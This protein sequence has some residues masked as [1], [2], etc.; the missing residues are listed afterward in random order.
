LQYL[1]LIALAPIVHHT[2]RREWWKGLA[3]ILL[4]PFYYCFLFPYVGIRWLG[5]LTAILWRALRFAKSPTGFVIAMLLF[6]VFSIVI[7]VVRNPTALS[8]LG[9]ANLTIMNVLFLCAVVFSNRP[10]DL[11]ILAVRTLCRSFESSVE[12]QRKMELASKAEVERALSSMQSLSSWLRKHVVDETGGLRNVEVLRRWIGPMF[13]VIVFGLFLVFV[14]GYALVYYSLQSAGVDVLPSLGEA[15]SVGLA[16]YN[17]LTISTTA[18]HQGV[19]P[20]SS[21]GRVIQSLHLISVLIFLG[22][23]LFLFSYAMGDRGSQLLG[24]LRELPKRGISKLDRLIDNL[25][26]LESLPS[27]DGDTIDMEGEGDEAT[28]NNVGSEP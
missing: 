17:S 28:G 26:S 15:P 2:I 23:S 9:Y 7:P 1:G 22:S 6:V 16:W 14:W 3:A 21:I 18:L 27:G 12:A 11:A 25:N 13:A 4:P 24:E 8:V 20:N 19:I 10:L 5:W